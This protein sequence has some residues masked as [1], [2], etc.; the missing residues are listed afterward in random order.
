[1]TRGRC[2][3]D[4]TCGGRYVGEMVAE[5][6]GCDARIYAI[7]NSTGQ[8]YSPAIVRY[9]KTQQ[10]HAVF[11]S[12]NRGLVGKVP[13]LL[14]TTPIHTSCSVRHER[15]GAEIHPS[16]LGLQLRP[17]RGSRTDWKLDSLLEK[18]FGHV[19]TSEW[20]FWC[21]DVDTGT[22]NRSRGSETEKGWKVDGSDPT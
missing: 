10:L 21:Q 17:R 1:M 14:S 8:M 22:G 16:A 19:H 3:V 5:L 12:I 18:L 7:D 11:T 20:N 15:G 9:N 6:L 4:V 13:P 2:W